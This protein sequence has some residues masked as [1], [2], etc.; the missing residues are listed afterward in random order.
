ML[1]RVDTIANAQGLSRR[2]LGADAVQRAPEA[3]AGFMVFADGAF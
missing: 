2:W 3:Q 1:A